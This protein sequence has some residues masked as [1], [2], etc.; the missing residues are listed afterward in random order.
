MKA[1]R[2]RLDKTG[3]PKQDLENGLGNGSVQPEVSPSGNGRNTPAQVTE[4]APRGF[5]PHCYESEI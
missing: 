1:E 2:K 5:L 3:S 4:L